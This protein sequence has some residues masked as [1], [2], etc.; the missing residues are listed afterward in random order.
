MT[1]NQLPPDVQAAATEAL[2]EKQLE[3]W[4]LELAGHGIRPIAYRMNVTPRVITDRLRR[5]H[6]LLTTAGIR[7][8]HFG[9]WHLTD[10]EAA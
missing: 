2:T 8:D 5:A 9:R 10:Q 4:K 3:T 1:W 6:Q 7:Q